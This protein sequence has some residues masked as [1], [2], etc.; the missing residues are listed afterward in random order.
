MSIHITLESNLPEPLEFTLGETKGLLGVNFSSASPTPL[1]ISPVV[2]GKTGAAGADAHVVPLN[3]TLT[4]DGWADK[5]QVVEVEDVTSTNFLI[6]S[7]SP[8]SQTEYIDCGV[9][10][11]SQ[12]T[13][14]LTFKC[15]TTPTVELYVNVGV[16]S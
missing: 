6:V 5:T 16:F 12:D 10:C 1:T 8:A 4:V 7:P 2:F 3:L 9:L 14:S 11:W 15:D 13:N